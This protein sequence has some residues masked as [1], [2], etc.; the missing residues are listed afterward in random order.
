MIE[1][2]KQARLMGKVQALKK[3]QLL[4]RIPHAH[5]AFHLDEPL[6]LQALLALL[7]KLSKKVCTSVAQTDAAMTEYAHLSEANYQH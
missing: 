5:V 2:P 4:Q 1:V 3:R 7:Q 6:C